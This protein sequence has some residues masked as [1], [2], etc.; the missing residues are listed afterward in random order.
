MCH[1]HCSACHV[2]PQVTIIMASTQVVLPLSSTAQL[3]TCPRESLREWAGSVDTTNTLWPAAASLTPK[4][5]DRLVFPTPPL[6]EIMM[7]LRCVPAASSSKQVLVAAGSAAGEAA[8]H[9]C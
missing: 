4:L 9:T 1:L 6:P 3:L 8:L 7:Y 2:E 5:A